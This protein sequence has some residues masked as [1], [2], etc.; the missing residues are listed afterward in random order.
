MRKHLA[1]WVANGG[2][3]TDWCREHSVSLKTACTWSGSDWFRREVEAHRR[4]AADRAIA[5]MARRLGESVAE[6]DRLIERGRDDGARLA[7]AETLVGKLLGVRAHAEMRAG[8]RRLAERIE[9]LDRTP[10]P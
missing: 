10:S 5:R 3:L 1:L 7:A 2:K 8:L 9:A 6:I 4:R